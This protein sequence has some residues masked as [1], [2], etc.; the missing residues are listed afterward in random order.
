[1]GKGVLLGATLTLPFHF[2][3]HIHMHMHIHIRIHVDT[4]RTQE[5]ARCSH[6]WF[7]WPKSSEPFPSPCPCPPHTHTLLTLH[8]HPL[9][10]FLRQL[11]VSAMPGSDTLVLG[12]DVDWGVGS[13][14]VV[15]ASE[16]GAGGTDTEEVEVAEVIDGH[17]LR[18]TKPLTRPHRV[19]WFNQPGFAP[20]DMRVE[21]GLLTRNVVI[22]G[23]EGSTQQL[24]GAH[25]ASMHGA[26]L[27]LSGVE[28]RRCGQ[29]FVLGRY[30]SHLHMGGRMEDSYIVDNSIHHSFQRAVTVHATHYALIKNNVAYN[31]RGHTYFVEVC[32]VARDRLSRRLPAP[33][34]RT[35]THTHATTHYHKHGRPAW[36]VPPSPPFLTHPHTST[37]NHDQGQ[38]T[39]ATDVRPLV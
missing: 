5:T 28:I 23:D 30:C 3:V 34:P 35:R 19:Q 36:G 27:R 15:T 32:A 16:R 38:R 13:R 10:F 7:W 2:A 25:V 37:L 14:L 22:Q 18:L 39:S 8:H 11:N 26:A 12:E 4:Q 21:V 17:T 9:S 29:A 33:T 20:V 1:M 31:V 6:V 24:Y